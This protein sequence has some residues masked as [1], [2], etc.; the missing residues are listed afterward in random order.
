MYIPRLKGAKTF[1]NIEISTI[2]PY[3]D[4]VFF[5]KAWGLPGRF[6]GLDNFCGCEQ[7]LQNFLVTNRRYGTDKAREA[8]NL[9]VDARN[10]LKRAKDENLLHI[11]ARIVFSPAHS[12]NEGIMLTPE[13]GEDIYLPMLRQQHPSEL[14]GKCISLADFVSPESD[15]IGLF[16][17]CIDGADQLSER[18][19][20]EGDLYNSI[21]IKSVADRLAEATAEWLHQQVRTTYWGYAPDENYTPKELMK[22]PFKGIRPAIGYPAIPDQRIIFRVNQ[23]LKMEEIGMHITENGAMQPNASIC[24]LYISHPKSFYF[25]VGKV[26]SDQLDDYAKRSGS[27]RNELG[28]WLMHNI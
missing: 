26:G 24:G 8:M 25:M 5:F 9:F 6:D 22:L 7:C 20:T 23:L 15:F 1:E 12:A 17:L 13:D 28:K 2:A 18:Y 19:K 11:R 4:W 14:V 21:L 3:I 27:D 10:M 16:S